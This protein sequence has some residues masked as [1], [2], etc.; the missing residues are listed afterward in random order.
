MSRS[1]LRR[2]RRLKADAAPIIAEWK[3]SLPSL[4]EDHLLRIIAVVQY[5]SLELM[6]HSHVH[7]SAPCRN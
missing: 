4:A 5:G 2:I 3:K 7:I 6:N 1:T